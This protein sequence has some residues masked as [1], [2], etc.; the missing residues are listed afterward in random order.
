MTLWSTFGRL[1]GFRKVS[2]S[3]FSSHEERWLIDRRSRQHASNAVYLASRRL[4][5]SGAIQR[6]LQG[7]HA[8]HQGQNI[9]T[10]GQDRPVLSVS[11]VGNHF[12]SPP[13]I[14]SSPEDSEHEVE[15][16]KAGVGECIPFPSIWGHWAGGK[17][18]DPF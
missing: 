11:G 13:N 10:A 15:C 8:R 14:Q 6:R 16:M 7:S 12:R 17:F 5:S 18:P 2:T 3:Y 1:G 9:G 4:L